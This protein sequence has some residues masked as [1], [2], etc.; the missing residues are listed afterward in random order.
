V[1]GEVDVQLHIFLTSALVGDE[2][3]ASRPDRFIPV[4]GTPG[5]H[6]IRDKVDPRSCLDDLEKTFDPTGNQIPIRRSRRARSQSLFRLRYP[7]SPDVGDTKLNLDN[8]W[9][10][11]QK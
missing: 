2:L 5:T 8:I 6:W 9:N 7:G 11:L 3:S 10:I 4:K 1:Y